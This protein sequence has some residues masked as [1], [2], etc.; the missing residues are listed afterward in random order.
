MS[1]TSLG[2]MLAFNFPPFGLFTLPLFVVPEADVVD[3]GCCPYCI[4]HLFCSVFV[5]LIVCFSVRP[6]ANH[7]PSVRHSCTTA[8]L[9]AWR[10]LT[11]GLASYSQS[12]STHILFHVVKV[13]TVLE[14]RSM[15]RTTLL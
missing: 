2:S 1:F 7:P 6:L 5:E 8:K 10:T 15:R 13:S 12:V 9:L 11:H 14:L 4:C 3:V